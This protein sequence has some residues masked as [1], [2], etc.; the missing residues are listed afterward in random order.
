MAKD[1]QLIDRYWSL[2]PRLFPIFDRLELHQKSTGGSPAHV[3]SL[4]I[5]FRASANEVD[6]LRRLHLSF[7]HVTTLKINPHGF[8]QIP[9][10]EI[11]SIQEY[12][13][14]GLKYRVSDTEENQLSFYCKQFE[15]EIV[16]QE[17][18]SSDT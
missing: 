9:V 5:W 16:N 15:V 7:D 4:E 17:E 11:V 8:I 12:Q 3:L 13:W 2:N 14:E 1:D 6:D 18:I 10:F